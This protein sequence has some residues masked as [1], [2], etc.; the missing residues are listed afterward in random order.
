MD[1]LEERI[2]SYV[3]MS[4]ILA[5]MEKFIYKLN[6]NIKIRCSSSMNQ[7]LETWKMRKG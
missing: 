2:L 5:Y 6:G 3:K 7:T 1:T 4:G